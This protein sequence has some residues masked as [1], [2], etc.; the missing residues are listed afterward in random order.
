MRFADNSFDILINVESSLYYPRVES[1]LREVVRVLKPS[2]YFLYAD[3]RFVEEIEIWKKQL[4]L[5]KLKSD[6]RARYYAECGQSSGF[7]L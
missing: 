4:Q 6:Q 7:G 3:I 1:F 2:G 5:L